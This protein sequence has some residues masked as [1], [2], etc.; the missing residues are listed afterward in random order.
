[1]SPFVPLVPLLALTMGQAGP[2]ID[3]TISKSYGPWHA[4]CTMDSLDSEGRVQCSA[5][6]TVDGVEIYAR[7]EGDLVKFHVSSPGCPQIAS[8]EMP[9]R[10]FR[11][12]KQE[13]LAG[14]TGTGKILGAAFGLKLLCGSKETSFNGDRANMDL[15]FKHVLSRDTPAEISEAVRRGVW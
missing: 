10:A 13:M 2:V 3:G 12:P 1:M 4:D 9:R 11:K 6:G 15:A 8:G 14:V 7:R 5:G